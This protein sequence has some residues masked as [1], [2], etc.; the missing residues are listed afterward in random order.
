MTAP[1]FPILWIDPGKMTGLA[2]YVPELAAKDHQMAG[3]P[4]GFWAAEEEFERAGDHIEGIT[5]RWNITMRAGWE[6]F[7]VH[8]R[9]PGD[10]A[11]HAIEM[12][13]VARRAIMKAGCVQLGPA[14]PDQR[15]VAKPALLE[16]VG[17]WLP[18][19]DDAQSAAQHMLAYMLRT[20]MVPARE[21]VIVDKLIREKMD[22]DGPKRL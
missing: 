1:A 4:P 15:L 19:R 14:M 16:A 9:T 8:S 7:R 17:W 18:G 2:L 22:D 6:H 10:D 5:M 3:F 20:G 21:R 11:H 13:G 12:I